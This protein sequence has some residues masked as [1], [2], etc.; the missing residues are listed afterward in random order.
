MK[1][2][3]SSDFIEVPS[4]ST[5]SGY[6]EERKFTLKQEDTVNKQHIR[7]K[8][9]CLS[10]ESSSDDSNDEEEET[11]NLPV[12]Q[13]ELIMGMREEHNLRFKTGVLM[14]V[15]ADEGIKVDILLHLQSLSLKDNF[16]IQKLTSMAENGEKM[17]FEAFVSGLDE[18]K[19]KKIFEYYLY[20]HS[21]LINLSILLVKSSQLHQA[22]K[23]NRNTGKSIKARR[24]RSAIRRAITKIEVIN[25][26]QKSE[27]I[28]V[29]VPVPEMMFEKRVVLTIDKLGIVLIY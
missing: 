28:D 7:K 26:R 4:T 24:K 29:S 17:D 12:D 11:K 3:G 14:N 23:G 13:E 8:D 15:R 2:E 9:P 16:N 10:A 20:I 5:S 1:N 27:N 6:Y 19:R 25:T 18:K 22:L 21:L